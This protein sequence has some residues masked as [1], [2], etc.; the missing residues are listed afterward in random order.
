VKAS[1]GND[2]GTDDVTLVAAATGKA[3][4]IHSFRLHAASDVVAHVYSGPS[5]TGTLI[6]VA[7]V[8]TSGM[9]WEAQPSGYL[10]DTSSGAAL[11]L[12]LQTDVDVSYS[13]EYTE[14]G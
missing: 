12:D 4:R 2:D 10:F 1:A 7:T 11:V 14:M 9:V 13:V 8:G 3:L 5:A 6:L